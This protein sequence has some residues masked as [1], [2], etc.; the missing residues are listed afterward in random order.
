LVQNVETRNASVHKLQEERDG[1]PVIRTAMSD[2]PV[3]FKRSKVKANQRARE[4]PQQ[5]A[6]EQRV[7]SNE[8]EPS[9]SALA[10]KIRH[11][12]RQRVK[13][14]PKTSLSFGVEE[15][16][17]QHYSRSITLH[18]HCLSQEGNEEIFKIKKSSLSQKLTL[19]QH[20]ASQGCVC[21]HYTS[22]SRV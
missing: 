12:A 15:E 3:I 8:D 18:L 6:Q 5:D 11:K 22:E 7:Q 19:R 2:T 4:G 1:G 10:S 20:P 21:C 17:S 9:P 13:V 16:V 14:K